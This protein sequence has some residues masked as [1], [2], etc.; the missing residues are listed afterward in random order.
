MA[1]GTGENGWNII[2]TCSLSV[3]YG[4]SRFVGRDIFYHVRITYTVIINKDHTEMG[5][6]AAGGS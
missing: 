1:G 6:Q 3:E 5:V 2:N 4:E